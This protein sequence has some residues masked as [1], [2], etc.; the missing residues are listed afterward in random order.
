MPTHSLRAFVFITGKWRWFRRILSNT[1]RLT[2]KWPAPTEPKQYGTKLNHQSLGESEVAQTIFPPILGTIKCRELGSSKIL[3]EFNNGG[4]SQPGTLWARQGLP[5]VRNLTLKHHTSRA[6]SLA[7]CLPP[8]DFS[9]SGLEAHSSVKLLQASH[10]HV[11]VHLSWNLFNV[12]LSLRLLNNSS[13]SVLS[14]GTWSRQS[15]T[16]VILYCPLED[17]SFQW[18][19]VEM[20]KQFFPTQ[21]QMT[22]E[23]QQ[24]SVLV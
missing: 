24:I 11:L 3:L 2:T 22:Y 7:S 15:W 13:W 16:H 14:S 23:F 20:Q 1:W 17:D 18:F 6:A 12:Y 8:Q 5:R 19:L 10:I 4:T 21:F 9:R